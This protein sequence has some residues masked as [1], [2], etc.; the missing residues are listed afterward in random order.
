MTD[1]WITDQLALIKAKKQ[2]KMNIEN[3][4]QVKSYNLIPETDVKNMV[5]FILIHQQKQD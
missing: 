2:S 1:C 4:F 3:N 5:H